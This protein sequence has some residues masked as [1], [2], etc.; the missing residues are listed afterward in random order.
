[1]GVSAVGLQQD[2]FSFASE[3]GPRNSGVWRGENRS[4]TRSYRED[5][6]RGQAPE[7]PAIL[8]RSRILPHWTK[9]E[10]VRSISKDRL[11]RHMGAVT[12][13]RI[14]SVQ[15]YVRVLLGL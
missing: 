1:M 5:F 12:Y 9:C 10:D 8:M 2:P 11:V 15:K 13:P 4:D 6:Q 14:E 7:G 3:G